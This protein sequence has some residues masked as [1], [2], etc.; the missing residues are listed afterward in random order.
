M[1][2]LAP[3]GADAGFVFAPGS[4]NDIREWLQ[5][6]NE[7]LSETSLPL[8]AA[9]E[10]LDIL[11]DNS[12]A[13]RAAVLR[14]EAWAEW[15]LDL[16]AGAA[17]FTWGED[18]VLVAMPVADPAT[19]R[20]AM[21]SSTVDIDGV[22]VDLWPQ[23]SGACIEVPG[24]YLCSDMLDTLAQWRRSEDGPL[25]ALAARLPRELQQDIIA[26]VPWTEAD[27]DFLPEL[28][29]NP[30]MMAF[31]ADVSRGTVRAHLWFDVKPT[32]AGARSMALPSALSPSIAATQ[33]TSLMRLAL[34][35]SDVID[36]LPPAMR[37]ANAAQLEAFTG[38]LFVYSPAS[39]Q[40][41]FAAAVGIQNAKPLLP[42]IGQVCAAI[43]GGGVP[44]LSLHTTGAGC[45]GKLDLTAIGAPAAA[46]TAIG[47]T[48]ARVA[49]AVKSDRV[50][51]SIGSTST[52]RAASPIETPAHA[53]GLI[54]APWMFAVWGTTEG[55]FSRGL[56]WVKDAS[57]PPS[58]RDALWLLLQLHEIAFAAAL[59]DDGFYMR[60][61]IDTYA[62][63][64]PAVYDA[65]RAATRLGLAGDDEAFLA[66]RAKL[67]ADHPNTRAGRE[68]RTDSLAGP[69]TTAFSLGILT[70]IIAN[71]AD[72]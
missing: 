70:A 21:A 60:A 55:M 46:F 61:D 51:L 8:E 49:L 2:A 22:A 25:A 13:G 15:G 52:E 53:R 30:T 39:R 41:W 42:L 56:G 20:E 6:A 24:Y 66:A 35:M 34:P 54:T 7:I 3:A 68:A 58:A 43:A 1:W 38:E 59:R 36:N 19:F 40:P 32:A 44:G 57:P 29:E 37:F 26:I 65:Y 45:E 27:G 11:D 5:V 72:D 4:L 48:E 64:P 23:N 47:V 16:T 10:E 62:A 63:D 14:E 28:V 18:G 9:L 12:A 17:V 69:A 31:G 50:E 71:A 33:P 67:A